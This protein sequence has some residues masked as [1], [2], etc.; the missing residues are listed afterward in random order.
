HLVQLHRAGGGAVA[1]VAPRRRGPAS[2]AGAEVGAVPRAHGVRRGV[3]VAVAAGA[4]ARAGAVGALALR[5]RLA[6]GGPAALLA[7]TGATGRRP[8]GPT[9]VRPAGRAAAAAALRAAHRAGRGRLVVARPAGR[10]APGGHPGE[11]DRAVD[12]AFPVGGLADRPAL[13]ERAVRPAARGRAL[14]VQVVVGHRVRVAA[15]GRHQLVGGRVELGAPLLVR[16]DVAPLVRLPD[17]A[18]RALL[19]RGLELARP[20]GPLLAPVDHLVGQRGALR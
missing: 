13:G 7:L 15:G 9:V 19:L 1:A 11:A 6:R 18:V 3:V 10:P 4:V 2:P 8:G 5:G 20:L 17:G 16:G 14:A 12:V